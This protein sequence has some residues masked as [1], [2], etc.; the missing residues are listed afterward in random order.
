[1][2][3]I[4]ATGALRRGPE[5]DRF[6]H[7][8]T[9]CAIKSWYERSML[10]SRDW[11]VARFILLLL[12]TQ[13]PNGSPEGP[14]NCRSV[15]FTVKLTSPTSAAA[16]IVSVWPVTMR[17]VKLLS[18]VC[19]CPFMRS[20]G[21]PCTH[22]TRVSILYDELCGNNPAIPDYLQTTVRLELANMMHA[23]WMRNPSLWKETV[24]HTRYSTTVL[25]NLE[26][27]NPFGEEQVPIQDLSE[28]NE[29]ER[30]VAWSNGRALYDQCHR[31][32][33]SHGIQA[34]EALQ[35]LMRSGLAQLSR[36]ILP[37]HNV[38]QEQPLPVA[39]RDEYGPAISSDGP[40]FV[41]HNVGNPN[42]G[43]R[44]QRYPRRRRSWTER[45]G[46]A[47]AR[48]RR[49]RDEFPPTHPESAL[50]SRSTS[51]TGRGPPTGPQLTAP[52]SIMNRTAHVPIVPGALRPPTHPSSSQSTPPQ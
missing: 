12:V 24:I 8:F 36:N 5:L 32:A 37:G 19:Q 44:R 39:L 10:P 17:G 50:L 2:A 42:A 20:A 6:M 3:R 40:N 22:A 28:R 31:K 49:N 33:R 25:D 18:A 34:A 48:S 4:E 7:T 41:V 26:Q 23:H 15:D 16:Y 11:R 13:A 29:R 30:A 52:R 43:N 51:R 27:T 21:L 47:S 14:S 1:M 38:D 9:T 35:E 46:N 45:V